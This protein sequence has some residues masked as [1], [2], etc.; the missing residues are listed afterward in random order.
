MF[1]IL[2]L[3]THATNVYLQIIL[4]CH[5]PTIDV[6]AMTTRVSA[7]DGLPLVAGDYEESR[8]ELRCKIKCSVSNK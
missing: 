7:A 3:A 4:S 8:R 2:Q 1:P 5:V 6:I